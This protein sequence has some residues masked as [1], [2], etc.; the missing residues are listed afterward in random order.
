GT[1]PLQEHGAYQ[2]VVAEAVACVDRQD[3]RV[4]FAETIAYI[5]CLQALGGQVELV[6]AK[7][8][9]RD[10]CRLVLRGRGKPNADVQLTQVILDR[11]ELVEEAFAGQVFAVSNGAYLVLVRQFAYV[12]PPL[13]QKPGDVLGRLAVQGDD[14]H[15][16]QGVPHQPAFVRAVVGE[17]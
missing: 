8:D 9:L 12:E 17:H 15:A 14:S 4:R 10:A 6:R 1:V 2:A 7:G 16:G 11:V 13:L 3:H 5:G